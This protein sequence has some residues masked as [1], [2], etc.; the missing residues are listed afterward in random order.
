MTSETEL[1]KARF[2][3]DLNGGAAATMTT[4]ARILAAQIGEVVMTLNAVHRTMFVVR[5]PEDQRLITTQE[6]FTQ[7]QSRA[8]ARQCKQ[9]DERAECDCQQEPRMPSE[10]EPPEQARRLSRLSLG[11]RT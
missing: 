5:K 10:H 7:G 8:T 3:A 9:R 1:M 11:A 6:R 2:G 4:D